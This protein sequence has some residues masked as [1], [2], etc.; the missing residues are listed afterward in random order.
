MS[1]SGLAAPVASS[2]YGGIKMASIRR[3]KTDKGEWRYDVRYRTPD[4]TERSRT[5][6]TRKKANTYAAI[7]EAD[8]ARCAWIDPRDA[9]LSFGEVAGRWRA[10]NPTKRP[11]TKATDDLMLEKHILPSFAERKIGAITRG[12][13]QALVNFWAEKA[14]PRTVRRRFGVLSAVFNFAAESDWIGRSPARGIKLPPITTTRSRQLEPEEIAAIAEA[15][16][17]DYR[18]MVWIGAFLGLRWSEV[19]GLRIG[20]L[21]LLRR[22]LSVA[23]TVTRDAKGSPVFTAPKSDAGVRT[24]AMPAVLAE[25]LAAHLATR[26][27]TAVDADELVFPSPG[28]GPLRYANW[29][30]RV[31]KPACVKA[32]VATVH[33][34]EDTKLER[35]EGPGFHDLRR[36]NATGLVLARVDLKT[37]QT[38]LGHSDP[39]LTFAVYAQATSDAD[40]AAAEALE[41]HFL[42]SPRDTRGMESS[43]S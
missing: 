10:S 37:T 39:R 29:R 4:G 22:T 9:S 41:A 2:S 3:R 12:D 11:T 23:E 26:G 40:K 18:P 36:A 38:R 43:T 24:L 19:A 6:T 21:D 32:G 35:Y 17:E 7:A 15:M 13:V 34:N 30:R 33:K 14:A 5:F 8:K 27:T 25:M 31:W 28:G 1:R 20:R 16:A 42:G